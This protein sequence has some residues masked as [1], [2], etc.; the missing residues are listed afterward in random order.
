MVS[1]ARLLRRGEICHVFFLLEYHDQSLVNFVLIVKGIN[2]TIF[3]HLFAFFLKIITYDYYQRMHRYTCFFSGEKFVENNPYDLYGSYDETVAWVPQQ[4][5]TSTGGMPKE[6]P[7]YEYP[8]YYT[9]PAAYPPAGRAQ[10]QEAMPR[11]QQAARQGP[12]KPQRMSKAET[13]AMVDSFKKFLVVGSLI[14]FGLLGGLAASHITGATSS[15][16]APSSPETGPSID[17]PGP[18]S[19]SNSDNNGGFFNQGNQGNQFGPGSSQSPFTGSS[20]S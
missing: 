7:L 17:S 9:H 12:A 19:P 10:R 15:Q 6:E 14:S 13:L 16:A 1:A 20:T 5:Q 4:R 2:F 8:A 3:L 18:Q 11:R